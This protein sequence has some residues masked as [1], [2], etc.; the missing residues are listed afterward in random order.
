MVLRAK[1]GLSLFRPL[2]DSPI[3][4]EALSPFTVVEKKHYQS[5]SQ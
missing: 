1:L 4:P 3:P 2:R 5:D